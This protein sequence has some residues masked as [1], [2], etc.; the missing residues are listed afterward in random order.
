MA[1][2]VIGIDFGT[3]NT[4]L[5]VNDGE[6]GV[7]ILTFAAPEGELTAFRS[8]L[9]FREH[10]DPDRPRTIEAGPWAIEEYL[11]DPLDTSLS[12]PLPFDFS[13]NSRIL[14]GLKIEPMTN[15][16]ECKFLQVANRKHVA[17]KAR[18]ERRQGF[19]D[20]MVRKNF[21]NILAL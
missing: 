2:P 11:E 9:S 17:S 3:T 8:V 15:G 14:F 18:A 19:V 4:V 5:A 16:F 21:R 13:Q 7:A 10:P 1:I 12:R 6:G 20:R